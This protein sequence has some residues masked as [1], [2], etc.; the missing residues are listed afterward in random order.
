MV[1]FTAVLSMAAKPKSIRSKVQT[2]KVEITEQGFQP[3][4]F[5]LRRG[6]PARVTFIR[7]TDATCAKEVVIS[8]YNIK[9]DLPLNKAVVVTFTP[10]KTGEFTFS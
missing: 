3:G 10:D 8:A 1:L 2:A 5:K 4:S 6:I 9:R 7:K